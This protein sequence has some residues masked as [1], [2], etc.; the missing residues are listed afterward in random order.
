MIVEDTDADILPGHK[1]LL[2]EGLN[3]LGLKSG[4][5]YKGQAGE[6]QKEVV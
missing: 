4:Q 6:V 5:K 2:L 3:N 1:I